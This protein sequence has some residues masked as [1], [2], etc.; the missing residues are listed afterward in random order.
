MVWRVFTAHEGRITWT[1]VNVHCWSIIDSGA[2]QTTEQH[3]ADLWEYNVVLLG[4]PKKTLVRA[5]GYMLLCKHR[6]GAVNVEYAAAQSASI[7]LDWLLCFG[8]SAQKCSHKS[9]LIPAHRKTAPYLEPGS[10]AP[11]C[12]MLSL[13]YFQTFFQILSGLSEL[14]FK[15]TWNLML[16]LIHFNRQYFPLK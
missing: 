13:I 8:G 4:Q 11:R 14:R 16:D 1:C 6:W 12:Q 15:L 5:D 10:R 9:A 3:L 2:L 7:L